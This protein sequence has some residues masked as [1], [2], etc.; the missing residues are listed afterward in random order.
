MKKR[1]MA[2]LLSFS[3]IF[4]F[5]PNVKAIN[6]TYGNDVKSVYVGN[7]ENGESFYKTN[8]DEVYGV[9]SV[10]KLMT[11]LVIKDEISK[12][13]IKLDDM[14]DID[15]DAAKVNIPGYSR[16][17]LTVGEKISVKSLLEGLII[18]SANDGANALGKFAAGSLDGFTKMMNNK[19]KEIGL[20]K[21]IFVN[22]SGLTEE[23]ENGNKSFNQMSA[24]DMFN[25]ARYIANKY[26]E[27]EEYS[28]YTEWRIPEKPG[29]VRDPHFSNSGDPSFVG[30]KSGFTE[31]AGYCYAGLFDFSKENK[32]NKLKVVTVVI[33]ARNI[34]E[35]VTTTLELANYVKENYKDIKVLNND[36]PF[37]DKYDKNTEQKYISLYPEKN[38][39]KLLNISE[40]PK[41]EYNIYNDKSA[42]YADGE[43]LGE[44]KVIFRDGSQESVKLINKGYVSK[45]GFFSRVINSIEDF[46]ENI[47]ILF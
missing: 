3:I 38:I 39:T 28:T 30:L 9:A 1:L 31:E 17:N 36:I 34:S 2:I 4:S 24:R 11:Y 35:R 12:G 22:P 43:E 26:P 15:Q 32:E 16:M 27:I 44:I 25:M 14:V 46:F 8:E 20:T 40:N 45:L 42:P 29:Y 21:A 7:V 5:I 23:D 37:I 41:V 19:A 18:V 13:N 6:L 10:S 33:G 47:L